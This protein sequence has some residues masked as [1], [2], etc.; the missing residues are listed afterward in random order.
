[1]KVLVKFISKDDSQIVELSSPQHYHF[2]LAHLTDRDSQI[3][4]KLSYGNLQLQCS[5]LDRF[6]E[7][8]SYLQNLDYDNDDEY[9]QMPFEYESGSRF[10][11]NKTIYSN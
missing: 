9:P 3:S 5:T 7:V 11:D 2:D 10:S 1:M 6:N 4:M 8:V